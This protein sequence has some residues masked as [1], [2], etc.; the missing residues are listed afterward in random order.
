MSSLLESARKVK[1]PLDDN[2]EEIEGDTESQEGSG[3][4][5]EGTALDR[6][7]GHNRKFTSDKFGQEKFLAFQQAKVAQSYSGNAN[8]SNQAI[9]NKEETNWID[10]KYI[11]NKRAANELSYI[12]SDQILDITN[13]HEQGIQTGKLMEQLTKGL[14]MEKA[15]DGTVS[16]VRVSKKAREQAE[17]MLR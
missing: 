14:N 17:Y 2:G 3:Q 8:G 1:K 5:G 12:D 9:S 6:M 7:T 4:G 13:P 10:L 16:N 11:Q 15:F